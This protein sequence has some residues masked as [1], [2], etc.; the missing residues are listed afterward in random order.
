MKSLSYLFD[1]PS[2]EKCQAN[3]LQTTHCEFCVFS[4]FIEDM[5]THF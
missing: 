4:T 5:Q 3:I 2:E 1:Q